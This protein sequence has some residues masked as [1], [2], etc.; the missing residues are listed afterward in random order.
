M[1]EL[2]TLY[3]A[4]LLSITL[5]ILMA[6]LPGLSS[7]QGLP[8][9]PVPPEN[10]IT[11]EKR[12]LGKILFWEEQLSSDNTVA[13]GT[14]HRLD[15][16]GG[17]DP[18]LNY[19]PGSDGIFGT[20]DDVYG[21]DNFWDGRASGTFR[22]PLTNEILIPTG[23]GL[24]SQAMGPIMDDI[25]MAFEGRTWDAVTTKLA[26]VT[27]LALAA[28]LPPDV[29]A[30]LGPGVSYGDLFTAAFGDPEITPARLAFA[31][32]TYERTLVPDQTPWDLY[33]AGDP[34]ALTQ[35]Q[36]SGLGIFMAFNC[37]V[38]HAP[39]YFTDSSFRNDGLRPIA[40]DTGRQE[41]TGLPED[42]GKFKV[43]SLRNVGLKPFLMHTGRFTSLDSVLHFY[44]TPA[45]QNL[46]NQ[47]PLLPV[48][49]PVPARPTL[50]EFL[51][52]GLT[53]PRVAAGEFPFDRPTLASEMGASAVPDAHP[54]DGPERLAAV[55]YPNPFNPRTTISFDL[56]EPTQVR[57]AVY[58]A[59]GRVV[60]V[61]ADDWREAGPQQLTWNGRNDQGKSVASGVYFY[62]V[63]A[64]DR[65][66]KGRLILVR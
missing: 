42:A 18:R 61:L 12:V 31:L 37:R 2:G 36:Q 66:A 21:E 40:E 65:Q 26:D 50:I 33:T 24:E 54:L 59:H 60:K 19:N 14:C 45:I 55:A 38:C 5:N 25:E 35:Q 46:E 22:D 32:A 17:G 9:V 23:G 34:D 3:R 16:A 11:E 48:V 20:E 57:V 63:V 6:G 52:N 58:S 30:V 56:T 8:P 44:G 1:R 47:D 29:A 4:I 39:P 49:I 51:A 41:V 27:P 13:C 10:P 53:D 64:G 15:T 62:R 43:P 28:D 7:A